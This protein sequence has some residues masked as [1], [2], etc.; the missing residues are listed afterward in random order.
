MILLVGG[1]TG[2]QSLQ[3]LEKFFFAI[4]SQFIIILS[5][6]TQTMLPTRQ[7]YPKHLKTTE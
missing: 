7:M 2:G 4:S 5:F 6:V 3:G 1:G